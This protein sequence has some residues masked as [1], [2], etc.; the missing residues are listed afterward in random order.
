M[1]PIQHMLHLHGELSI[2]LV[3]RSDHK[4]LGVLII[5]FLADEPAYIFFKFV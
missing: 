5:V 4:E 2:R 3:E 1:L